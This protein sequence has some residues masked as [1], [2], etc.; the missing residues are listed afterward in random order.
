MQSKSRLESAA[1]VLK[2]DAQAVVGRNDFKWQAAITRDLFE[3]AGFV[4]QASQFGVVVNR[5]VVKHGE[6][7]DMRFL[8]E[9]NADDVARMPP[10]GFH[11]DRIG[12]AVHGVENDKV[13]V[14]KEFDECALLGVLTQFVL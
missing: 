6:S 13:G 2:F 12:Q 1:R 8:A 4:K 7:S 9:F 5:F 3:M 10:V 14:L 11:G